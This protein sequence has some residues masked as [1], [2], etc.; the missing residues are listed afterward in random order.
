MHAACGVN[1]RL[2]AGP[3]HQ[4]D[5]RP[6]VVVEG[7]LSEHPRRVRKAVRGGGKGARVMAGVLVVYRSSITQPLIDDL[8]ANVV[9][10]RR[11]EDG[12]VEVEQLLV[13]KQGAIVS[14]DATRK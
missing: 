12:K 9:H 3:L 11:E 6:R 8:S 4:V 1:G 13:S 7:C 14:K 5:G 2:G 10:H